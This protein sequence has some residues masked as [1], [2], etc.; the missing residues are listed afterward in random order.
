VGPTQSYQILTT[1]LGKLKSLNKALQ[2]RARPIRTRKRIKL[3]LAPL[4]GEYAEMLSKDQRLW[5]QRLNAFWMS[6]N[7]A[8]VSCLFNL[9]PLVKALSLPDLPTLPSADDGV[10]ELFALVPTGEAPAGAVANAEAED[11]K[12]QD[13]RHVWFSTFLQATNIHAFNDSLRA[14]FA[15]DANS[16][17]S[18]QAIRRGFGQALQG[19]RLICGGFHLSRLSGATLFWAQRTVAALLDCERSWNAD[20]AIALNQVEISNVL[21]HAANGGV[22]S[23]AG[24]LSHLFDVLVAE[25]NFFASVREAHI[26]LDLR[27]AKRIT[28]LCQFA[29]FLSRPSSRQQLVSLIPW[30]S[31]NIQLEN[32]GD[33]GQ[34]VYLTF[35]K[36]KGA[37]S[38]GALFWCVAPW[39]IPLLKFYCSSV[40]D[41]LLQDLSLWPEENCTEFFFPPH[42]ASAVMLA[43]F[44]KTS[45]MGMDLTLAQVRHVF[46]EFV[47]SVAHQP[48]HPWYSR[49]DVIQASAAHGTSSCVIRNYDVSTKLSQGD[50]LDDFVAENCVLPALARA[51]D[52]IGDAEDISV[53]SGPSPHPASAFSSS[54]G[55][56]T[57]SSSSSSSSSSNSQADP[58]SA[59]ATPR[60]R[61]KPS[62]QAVAPDLKS[63]ASPVCPAD[64]T[65][66]VCRNRQKGKKCMSGREAPIFESD[67]SL[68]CIACLAA[69]G[70]TGI[71]NAT[72]AKKL[73]TG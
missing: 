25:M 48:G 27:L 47:Q 40:R 36:H 7:Q 72:R 22:S 16:S 52:L 61:P 6:L 49:A 53:L 15:E 3:P 50:L 69:F 18:P 41:V 46:C 39:I 9:P 67:A 59:L 44:G 73:K 5:F 19:T 13:E 62:V 70:G 35:A 58:L 65:A 68:N 2:K 30:K 26:I 8:P 24:A 12:S 66:R 23:P 38:Y 10:D 42:S 63:A 11:M 34:K 14:S 29:L 56:S 4:F 45:G 33:K 28:A 51:Q 71:F 21:F 64:D 55:N 57:S 54:S 32:V 37:A 43:D 31:T 1:S 20:V 17:L 60:K